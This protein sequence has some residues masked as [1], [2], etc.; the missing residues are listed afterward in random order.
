MNQ[1]IV[2]GTVAIIMTVTYAY[3]ADEDNIEYEYSGIVRDIS[4]SAN[5]YTFYIDTS[6][7]DMKCYYPE[8][9]VKYGHYRIKGSLSSD[10]SIYFV[11]WMQSMDVTDDG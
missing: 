10:G 1:Y 11:E 4:S 9:P 6:E 5:G 3:F 8:K 2:I 7:G